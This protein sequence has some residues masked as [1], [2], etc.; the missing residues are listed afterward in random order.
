M[1][2]IQFTRDSRV[3][4]AALLKTDKNQKQCAAILGMHRPN[5]GREINANKDPDGAYR[6][7]SAHKRALERRRQGK[8]KSKKI[9]NNPELRKYIIRKLKK[10]WSPEQIAGRLKKKHE[11]SVV[12]HETIYQFIYATPREKFMECCNSD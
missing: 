7:A 6:G 12:C 5:I 11:S 1:S 8:K 3:E 9:E 4:L 2:H 10:F